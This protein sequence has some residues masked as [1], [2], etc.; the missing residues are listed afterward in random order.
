MAG[1]SF[2]REVDDLSEEFCDRFGPL[3]AAA[4]RLLIIARLRIVAAGLG[5][6]SVTTDGDRLLLCTDGAI[7]GLRER[8]IHEAL[9]AGSPP[10]DTADALLARATEN[11]G[12]DDITLTVA[13]VCGL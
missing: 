4:H 13:D 9:A 7:D 11:D 12:K 1:V 6:K 5:L 2:E 8:H 10:C 3:P